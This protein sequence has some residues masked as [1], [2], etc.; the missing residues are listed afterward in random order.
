MLADSAAQFCAREHV[1]KRIRACRDRTPGF[2]RDVWRRTAELGWLG[3]VV[4]EAD[5]G[6]GLGWGDLA[7]V[8]GPW[9]AA[10]APEPL[11]AVGVLAARV[12]VHGDGA[13]RAGLLERLISGER[14]VIAILSISP[15]IA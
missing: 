12:L 3:I 7:Q 9:G 13:A 8:L 14:V 11:V 1:E 5:S 15:D 6:L 2:D 4:P 10:C